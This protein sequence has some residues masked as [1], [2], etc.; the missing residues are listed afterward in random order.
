MCKVHVENKMTVKLYQILK[1][2]FVRGSSMPVV[3]LC[4]GRRLNNVKLLA[5]NVGHQDVAF[6]D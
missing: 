6:S 2:L 1:R 4:N 3:T 5:F